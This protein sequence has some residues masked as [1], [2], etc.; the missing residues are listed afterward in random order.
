MAALCK[1]LMGEEEQADAIAHEVLQGFCAE[2]AGA[3]TPFG[4]TALG[5]WVSTLIFA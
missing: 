1:T 4:A 5:I 2:T 3:H